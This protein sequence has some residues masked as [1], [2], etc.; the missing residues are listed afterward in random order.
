MGVKAFSSSAYGARNAE[1]NIAA[2]KVSVTHAKSKPPVFRIAAKAQIRNYRES[3]FGEDVQHFRAGSRAIYP[4]FYLGKIA[5]IPYP[6][7]HGIQCA[8][9]DTVSFMESQFIADNVV[10]CAPVILKD[11][12][13]DLKTNRAWDGLTM[14]VGGVEEE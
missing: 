1:I 8:E 7:R 9:G 4:K 12:G 5:N 2:K 3:I 14:Q 10:A 13:V 6:H 11:N